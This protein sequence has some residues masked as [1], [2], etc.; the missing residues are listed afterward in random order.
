MILFSF[1]VL[2][3]EPSLEKQ[4]TENLCMQCS[5]TQITQDGN[6]WLLLLLFSSFSSIADD[7]RFATF[8]QVDPIRSHLVL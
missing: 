4:N 8:D 6:F 3:I 1:F 2:L 7:N 5:A